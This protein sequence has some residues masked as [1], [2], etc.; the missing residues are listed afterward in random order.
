MKIKHKHKFNV[1][2]NCWVEW[3]KGAREILSAK[4]KLLKYCDVCKDGKVIKW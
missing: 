1:Y 2:R 3:Q 4:V